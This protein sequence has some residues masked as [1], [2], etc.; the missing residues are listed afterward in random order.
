MKA[1][2][3]FIFIGLLA[4]SCGSDNENNDGSVVNPN[5]NNSVCRDAYGNVYNCNGSN[6][7]GSRNLEE[8]GNI[9]FYSNFN[10]RIGFDGIRTGSDDVFLLSNYYSGGT[11]LIANNNSTRSKLSRIANEGIVYGN[12][13]CVSGQYHQN[14]NGVRVL[15]VNRVRQ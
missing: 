6:R 12:Y 1:L 13:A 10:I 7:Y 11:I 3:H 8:C 9:K 2:L 4:V 5:D 15:R 14:A